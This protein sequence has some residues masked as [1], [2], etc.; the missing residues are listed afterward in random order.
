MSACRSACHRN[1]ST[2]SRVSDVS[3]RILREDV[4]VGVGVVECGL[5]PGRP[6]TT[7]QPEDTYGRHCISSV[8]YTHLTLPTILRV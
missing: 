1:N 5:N 2:K 7:D 6:S 3:A 8:S 4:G